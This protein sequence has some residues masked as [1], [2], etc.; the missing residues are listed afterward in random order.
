MTFD[1]YTADSKETP[2]WWDAVPRPFIPEQTPPPEVD[3][4]VV[5]SG[6]TGLS[7]AL[8]TARAGRSTLV[9]DA[10][11]AGWGCSSRNGGQVTSSFK[12]GLADLT[13]K[14]GYQT[15]LDIRLE[16]Y[17][18]IDYLEDFIR[19]ENIDCDWDRAGHF[20]AAHNPRQYELLATALKDFPSEF[21]EAV[22]MVPREEQTAEIGSER[23]FGGAVFTKQAALHPAK[24][25]DGLLKSAQAHGVQVIAHCR[26]ESLERNG[27]GF[28]VTT[29]K[30]EVRAREVVIGTNGYT[31]PLTPWQRRRVIPIGSYI[32]ATE[33]LA[34]E[35]A[36]EL[37][38]N[39]RTF[40][41]TRR[42]VFYYRLSPDRTSMLFGG[43]VAYMESD[44]RVSA[45]R[46]H[47]AMSAIFP[48]LRRTRI[49][50]S[51]MGFVAYTFDELPHVGENEGLYYAMGYCGLGIAMGA[52]L[53]M[54]LGKKLLGSA[55]G[56]TPLDV[57]K[58]SSRPLYHGSPWFLAPSI[59]WYRALDRLPI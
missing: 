6:Y 1:L 28:R 37:A 38:P 49:T 46:L 5:G 24:F 12:R 30:G 26:V 17:R 50:H 22:H 44:P 27:A 4:L 42:V 54:R 57:A 11:E 48:Q 25:H 59:A 15:A 58:F 21:N 36:D 34:P 45:P 41:D 33:G 43:R 8:Q 3:V 23:Y 40:S 19:G 39:G 9:V 13:S 31:G 16:G 7:A 51:W 14:Y 2:Y 55:E 53:G 35:L 10:E 20:V 18:A 47:D 32:I 52:Y 56:N 29:S